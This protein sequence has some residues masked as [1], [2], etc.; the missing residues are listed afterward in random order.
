MNPN[1]IE[2]STSSKELMTPQEVSDFT[3]Y[4]LKA[5]ATHRVEKTGFPYYKFHRRIFYKH[6]EIMEA[7]ESGKVETSTKAS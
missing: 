1:N 7:I 4:S 2:E 5:L 3:G 6:S